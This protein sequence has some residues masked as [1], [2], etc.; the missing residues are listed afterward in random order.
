[1]SQKYKRKFLVPGNTIK[2]CWDFRKQCTKLAKKNG[3]KYIPCRT[4]VSPPGSGYHSYR[5]DET[6][7]PFP[8]NK[9][10]NYIVSE[11]I[12]GEWQCS[13][14]HWKFRR[15]E[16]SHIRKAQAD[17]EKYEIAKEFTGKTTDVISK[18]FA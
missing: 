14:P 7:C 4:R 15:K 6:K 18:L 13:C 9:P 17:P 1:M 12:D 8:I 16:C 2:R 10:K 5:R 3:S 11:T